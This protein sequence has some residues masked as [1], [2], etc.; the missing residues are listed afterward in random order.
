[1]GYGSIALDKDAVRGE[2]HFILGGPT[3]GWSEVLNGEILVVPVDD[4]IFYIEGE[5]TFEVRAY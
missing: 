2:I 3:G 1:L 5:N 4:R